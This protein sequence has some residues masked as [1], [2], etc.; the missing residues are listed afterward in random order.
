M[1]TIAPRAQTS[2]SDDRF[3]RI[4]AIAMAVVVVAGFS[5]QLAMSRSSFASPL[6]VHLHALV[7]MGWVAIYV[8]QAVLATTGS[9]ALHRRLGWFATGWVGLMLVFGFVVT[10]ALV[11]EG[12]VPFFFTPLQ[13]LVFDPLS[14]LTFAALIFAGV[15]NRRRTDW[16][17]RLNFCAMAVLLG[18]AFGRL[19]PMPLF[20]PWAYEATL[21]AVLLFPVIGV[22][23][24][25]RRDG[26]VHPAWIWGI[27]TIVGSTLLVEAITFGPLGVPLY[28]AVTAGTP[29]A[30]IAPLE[31]PPPPGP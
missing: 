17:R 22:V 18:P 19:L 20:T 3:F 31:F 7:F 30:S 12:R 10:L 23:A 1:A 9:I 8:A 25:W 16:H 5:F 14:L 29:G 15:A 2:A 11:R 26:H 21:P 28:E 4:T 27:A 13:F 24:D 6:R